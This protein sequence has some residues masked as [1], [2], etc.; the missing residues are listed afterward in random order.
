MMLS[1]P[2]SFV[3]P[4]GLLVSVLGHGWAFWGMLACGY[5][6]CA[7]PRGLYPVKALLRP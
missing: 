6:G 3:L 7:W 1:R 4:D 5:S 2:S